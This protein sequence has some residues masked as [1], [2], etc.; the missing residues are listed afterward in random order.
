MVDNVI[1][2]GFAALP[3]LL[4]LVVLAFFRR[5]KRSGA[6]RSL[7]T[8]VLGNV[9]IFL[10]L[11]STVLLGGEIYYRF[12]Y[13]TTDA[14]GLS[15]TTKRWFMRHFQRN[16]DGFRD[17]VN[18]SLAIEPGK[19]RL[20][21]IGDSFLAG[22]G[23]P[24]VENRFANLIRGR[25]M[26]GEVHVLG[27]CGFDLGHELEMLETL[28]ELGYENDVVLLSYC[29]NDVSDVVPEWRGM[30]D[31]IYKVPSPGFL[32]EESYFLNKLHARWRAA[33]DPVVSDYY[34][35]IT[36][37]Y[38]GAEWEQQQRRL[39]Q[40]LE[41]IR[42]HDG[43]FLVVTF[44]FLHDLGPEYRYEFVH[45]NLSQFWKD[46]GV[47]HLD[48]LDLYQPHKPETLIVNAQDP[49]PNEF[50]HALAADAI[51]EFLKA[52][53]EASEAVAARAVSSEVMAAPELHGSESPDP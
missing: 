37:A 52:N 10:M 46:E 28:Y 5:L 8:I 4:L 32:F 51:A 20:T 22:H 33:R 17:T 27:R 35:F 18:Y 12:V 42:E 50:A 43:T 23:V 49:H 39:R 41:M 38:S 13:D 6:P 48:L 45:E 53:L 9:L 14:F 40:L 16:V 36:D 2:G 34:H 11:F 26:F 3:V 47:P 15:K 21:F 29:L 30:L 24:D 1:L 44:P 7:W 25:E 31:R 19:R